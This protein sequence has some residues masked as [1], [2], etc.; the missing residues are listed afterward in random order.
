MCCTNAT[1]RR[2][3][4]GDSVKESERLQKHLAKDSPTRRPV[5]SIPSVETTGCA[6]VSANY[7]PAVAHA[8]WTVEGV[9]KQL[10]KDSPTR[11]L[12]GSTSC[13]ETPGGAGVSANYFSAVAHPPKPRQCPPLATGWLSLASPRPLSHGLTVLAPMWHIALPQFQR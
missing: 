13:V 12:V 10:A 7:F 3:G 8:T 5:A 2:R 1:K 4:R 6:C 11:R 9:L